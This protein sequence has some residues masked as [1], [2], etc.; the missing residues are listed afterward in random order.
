V[1]VAASQYL[2][3][4]LLGAYISTSLHVLTN[5]SEV[6]IR[7]GNGGA[8]TLAVMRSVG[9]KSVAYPGNGIFSLGLAACCGLEEDNVR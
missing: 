4:W 9:A 6:S 2:F 8:T 7:V 5:R 1:R 3:A